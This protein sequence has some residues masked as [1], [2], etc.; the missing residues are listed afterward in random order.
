MVLDIIVAIILVSA[1]VYGLRKGF[2]FTFIHTAGWIGS[3]VLAYLATSLVLPLGRQYTGLYDWFL[4]YFKARFGD[5]ASALDL[6]TQTVP[7]ILADGYS[8][9]TAK[10]VNSVAATFAGIAYTVTVFLVLYILI[11]IVFWLIIRIFSKEY[12]DGFRGAADGFF[13]LIFGLI[14]G[15]IIVFLFLLVLLPVANIL[16]PDLTETIIATLDDSFVAGTLYDNN[17]ITVLLQTYF[18]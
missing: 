16:S 10:M 18:I 17:F 11:K 15:L 6:S 12:A 2:V 7:S 4:G 1:G 5:S 14:R 8:Q 9:L 13:G 3:L